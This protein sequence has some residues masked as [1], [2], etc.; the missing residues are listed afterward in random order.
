MELI[1]IITRF[2]FFVVALGSAGVDANMDVRGAASSAA[3]AAATAAANTAAVLAVDRAVMNSTDLDMQTLINFDLK[4]PITDAQGIHICSAYC[5]NHSSTCGGWV[6]VSPAFLP[7]SHYTGPRCSIKA[8]SPCR[9]LP[10]RTGLFAGA[11]GP[12]P[13]PPPSPSP[14]PLPPSPK[15][16]HG[17]PDPYYSRFHVQSLQHAIY[18]PDGPAF[19]NSSNDPEGTYHLF[20]QYNPRAT[21]KPTVPRR[22]ATTLGAGAYSAMQWYHW[23]SKDLLRWQHQPIA[24]APGARQDCGGI[25]SGSVTLVHNDTTGTVLPMITYS[26]PCMKVINY[27]VAA[28]TSDANL[29]K[30]TKVGTLVTRPEVV[31]NSSRAEM[32][33]PVPSWRGSDETWRM[34]AACNTLRACM[35]KAPTAMGP[36]T[37]VGGFG[38]TET[39][40]TNSFEC[41]DF[42]KVPQTDTY[43]LSTMGEGWAVGSYMPS[44]N[45]SLSD[46]F[47]PLH[48]KNVGSQLDQ[49]FDYGTP[50]STA[51]RT[52][53]DAKHDRQVLWGSN[54][55]Y[56][57]GSDW[58]GIM[59]FPRVVELDLEDNSRLISFP[60]PEISNLWT[61]NVSSGS[62]EVAAGA[63]HQLPASFGGNQLD[64]TFS[65]DANS[66]GTFGVR[67]LAP[68]GTEATRGVNVTVSTT[69][70]SVLA[71]LG[72][73][74]VSPPMVN[75]PASR[76]DFRISGPTIDLRVL[77]SRNLRRG[78]TNRSDGVALRAR[79]QN[80]HWSRSLQPRD[81]NTDRQQCCRTHGGLCQQTAGFPLVH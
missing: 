11:S 45:D 54:G 80:G 70:D 32:V 34:I 1:I 27:A 35:W 18:D 36:F 3:A 65:F 2:V 19:F 74:A 29:T 67:V 10:K 57:R 58:Q 28:N 76:T 22:S 5:T 81:R 4:K 64:V 53:F 42:W 20:A 78:W 73:G 79:S 9:T 59:S 41:P 55:G 61:S 56:C 23:T 62:F 39:N 8:K 46:V 38:N 25:W 31:T 13:P 49:L 21:L 6:Y 52:F 30:W 17:H 48:G 7:R 77:D 68:P 26:V 12:C 63:T 71:T 33:D 43:V 16:P 24:L 72:G 40:K 37:F 75:R 14:P 44:A 66:S 51:Q 47:V 15:P 50:G 69:S 60:L